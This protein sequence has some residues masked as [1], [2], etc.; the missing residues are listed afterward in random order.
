MLSLPTLDPYRILTRL[1]MKF[2]LTARVKIAKV[3][4]QLKWFQA[5]GFDDI[6]MI[7]RLVLE[8]ETGSSGF[9][10]TY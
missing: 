2:S 10:P 6:N 5:N 1:K 3:C 7:T 8:R 4:R 9:K